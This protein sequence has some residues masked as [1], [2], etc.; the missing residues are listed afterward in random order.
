LSSGG[1]GGDKERGKNR[2]SVRKLK[3]EMEH[4]WRKKRKGTVWRNSRKKLE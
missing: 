4:R 3:E 2:K 1:E